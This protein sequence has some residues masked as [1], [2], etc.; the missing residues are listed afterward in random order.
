MP[1]VFLLC[2]N[3]NILHYFYVCNPGRA[4]RDG[5]E[6]EMFVATLFPFLCL[7]TIIAPYKTRPLDCSLLLVPSHVQQAKQES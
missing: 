4:K 3:S 5:E 2:E 6:E 7:L 1:T